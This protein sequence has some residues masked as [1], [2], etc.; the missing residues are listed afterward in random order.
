MNTVAQTELSLSDAAEWL[1]RHR[2]KPIARQTLDN[3]IKIGCRGVKLV[4]WKRGGRWYTSIEALD[5]FSEECTKLPSATVS[6][7]TDRQ[8][9]R[10]VR[11]ARRVLAASGFYA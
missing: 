2:G 8:V 4:A 7:P 5:Q 11:S 1:P 3:W 6:L 9:S 10:G